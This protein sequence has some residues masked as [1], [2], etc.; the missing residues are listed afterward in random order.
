MPS[1]LPR[2]P[3]ARH[4]IAAAVHLAFAAAGAISA[5]AASSTA[6]AQEQQATRRYDIPAGSLSA[7]LNQFAAAAGIFLAG[8]AR[9]TGGRSSP[10]LQ[11]EYTVDE[12]LARLL[13]GSGVDAVLLPDG[14]YTLRELP[15]HADGATVL[16]AVKVE[17]RPHLD[18]ATENTGSYTATGPASSATGLSLTPRETPQSISVLTR[19]RI[20]DQALIT[21]DD[22]LRN[23]TGIAVQKGSYVGDSGSFSARGFE[24]SNILLDGLPTSTGANGTFNAD[25]DS[26][27]IY[28]RVEVVRGATGLMSGAGTPS[29]SINLVRKRPTQ[30]AQTRVTALAGSWD[31]RRIVVDA[32]TPL[33]VRGSVRVRTVVSAQDTAQFYDHVSDR[34]HLVYGIVD[35]DLSS[36]TLATVGF[37]YRRVDNDGIASGL[38]VQEDGSFY[39]G[40]RRRTNLSNAFDY[41]RQTDESVFAEL[42]QQLGGDWSA[43]LAA[44]WKRPEQD[45]LFSGLS[46]F[47]GT[48]YQDSQRYTLDSQQD[49]YDLSVR[50]SFT[51]FQRS[52]ELVF[53]AS[54]REYNLKAR[55]GWADYSW[56]TDGP[57]V[58][59]YHWDA[60]AVSRPE[61]D[62]S[63]WMQRLITKQNSFYAVSRWQLAEPLKLIAGARAHNYDF[64]NRRD[65][66]AYK[67]KNEITPYAGLL[68]DVGAQ[69][70][71]YASWTEIFEPQ[72]SLDRSGNYLDPITGV[73]YEA[74]IKGEYFDGRL[75]ASI[76]VFQIS[77]QNRA[78]DDLGG[79]N[80]CPGTSWGYCK[81]ASGEVESKGVEL[82]ISGT[83]TPRW[84]LSAGYTHATNKYTKD[85]DESRVG[86]PFNASLPRDQFNLSTSYRLPGVLERWRVGGNA[87]AQDGVE[88]AWDDRIRQGG[89]AIVGLQAGYRPTENIDLRLVVNNLLDKYYYGGVGWANGGNVF[90]APRNAVFTIDYRL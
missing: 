28:D 33:D 23:V 22:A 68:Y 54:T 9:L 15:P 53:G 69:H 3:P 18:S 89:Y 63:L 27:D 60:N 26:L 12:A 14:G 71:V 56:S 45:M 20:D 38:P 72:S 87:Y 83:L 88:G 66:V 10:G 78:V 47:D 52:H 48:L 37:H 5:A 79:P 35:A 61:I 85:A 64:E 31:N 30:T 4:R 6:I 77:Q 49:S 80:P 76:A 82:E 34:N 21:L 13:R 57:V 73:N 59:P 65:G 67:V 40:L 32:S 75:N 36:T 43:K 62:M 81:R 11:G 1:R 7:A 74:G 70:T 16:Q 19:A 2:R 17:A 24:I 41:W 58:D 42:V 29:A 50:G 86:T 44:V 90:G 8:D 55:G 51:L 39:P 25:N 84:D 46:R